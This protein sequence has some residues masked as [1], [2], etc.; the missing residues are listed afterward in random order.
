[1]KRIAITIAA[2]FV[3]LIGYSQV[4]HVY[5]EFNRLIQTDNGTSVIEYTYDELGNRLTREISLVEDSVVYIPDANF[6][7]ALV[8]NPEINSNSDTEIQYSEARAHA[9]SINVN[10]LSISDMTG[11]EAF[12]SLVYLNC[13]NNS[14]D[15]LDVHTLT[16][17]NTLY[18]ENNQIGYLNVDGLT[19]L[20]YLLCSNNQLSSIDVSTCSSLFM[21]YCF[22]NQI[23]SIDVTNNSLLARFGCGDNDLTIINMGTNNNLSW[24]FC[25]N[26]NLLKLNVSDKS[27]L[28]YVRCNN[29]QIDSLDF[30]CASKLT[31]IKCHDN[32]LVYLNLRNG[33]NLNINHSDTYLFNA[34][35]NPDLSCITVDDPVYSA[36]NWAANFDP[37]VTFNTDCSVLNV[38]V[39]DIH[40]RVVINETLGYSYPETEEHDPTITELNGLTNAL[41]ANNSNID[42]INGAQY[43]TGLSFLYL[44]GNHISNI[45]FLSALSNLTKLEL[46]GNHIEDISAV[47]GLTGLTRLDLSE[48]LI[49]D[50]SPVSGL[51][52]LS[53]LY[54]YDNQIT[55]ITALS[56]LTN[57][58]LLYIADNPI[59]DLTAIDGLTNLKQLYLRNIDVMDISA[60]TGLT[61]LTYL[62]L[63]MNDVSDIEPLADLMNL[64]TLDLSNNKITDIFSLI[65]NPELGA[66]D[67]LY[68]GLNP[69]SQEALFVHIPILQSRG[70]SDLYFPSTPNTYA[71]CYPFP[72]RHETAVSLNSDLEWRGNFDSPD[73]SYDVWLGESSDNLVRMG[74]ASPVND[75]VY[76]FSPV[77][78]AN[79]EYWWKVRTMTGTDTL[80]SGLWHF[81]TGGTPVAV[82]ITNTSFADGDNECF[83]AQQT[84]TIA[85]DGYPVDFLSGSSVNLIAGESISF[86]PGFHAHS[87]SY[88]DAW[89]TTTGSF[90]DA[91]PAATMVEGARPGT[92]K[93][94]SLYD[95]EPET[96]SIAGTQPFMKVYPNPATGRV[97][98]EW[99]NMEGP[100]QVTLFNSLGAKLAQE[101]VPSDAI[102]YIDLTSHKKGAYFVHVRGN[103]AQQVQ[104]IVLY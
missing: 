25:E 10:G 47:S 8:G 13:D 96:E 31:K 103:T 98:V 66:D 38:N 74:D 6:K 78:K 76:S 50:I 82:S 39:P 21:F 22:S 100:V 4:S 79:T 46:W 35:Q 72:G 58:N 43:L 19:N 28:S 77:L 16:Q 61:N 67:N 9:D 17:L 2:I 18:C 56:G 53:N 1:M 86:L 95:E 44:G 83:G 42:S 20:R 34:T 87:G 68:I 71:A 30:S 88:M 14:I 57:L 70:F 94:E 27:K 92:G 40:F 60:L 80:W 102:I 52:G 104:K 81:E 49:E 33:N 101:S 7:T 62:S 84:I 75:T 65:E 11:I 89:I 73:A 32:A 37:G 36:S 41:Y 48:N 3:T 23:T 99:V 69:L 26:N 59:R 93:S 63:S 24:L 90:C 64:S 97:R 54:L 91:L 45:S 55:D 85:G 12:I 29:N 15:S 5:D 51:S